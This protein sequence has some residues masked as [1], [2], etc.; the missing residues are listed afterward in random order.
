MNNDDIEYYGDG[1][2]YLS[3]ADRVIAQ[4]E[5]NHRYAAMLES[6]NAVPAREPTEAK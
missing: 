2:I 3:P 1:W 4:A 5:L 6:V